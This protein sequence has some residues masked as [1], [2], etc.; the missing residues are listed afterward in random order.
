MYANNQHNAP[1]FE[2]PYQEQ[3]QDQ[4]TQSYSQDD[5]EKRLEPAEAAELEKM[6]IAALAKG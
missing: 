3:R 4:G 6:L 5:G 1:S 2:F